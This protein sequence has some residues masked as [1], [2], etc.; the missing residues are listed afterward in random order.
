MCQD[1]PRPSI[2]KNVFLQEFVVVFGFGVGVFLGGKIAHPPGKNTKGI[3][4]NKPNKPK[5]ALPG[6]V[7]E[8]PKKQFMKWSKSAQSCLQNMNGKNQGTL[9]RLLKCQSDPW[10]SKKFV[11]SVEKQCTKVKLMLEKLI[12][13]TALSAT[14]DPST[15]ATKKFTSLR[16]EVDSIKQ[17]QAD[18]TKPIKQ[19]EHLLVLKN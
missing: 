8:C 11:A 1:D 5:P 13:V 18:S 4:N 14:S 19:A 10:C 12:K 9:E 3:E 6:P 7:D 15:F 17:E 16:A 2:K